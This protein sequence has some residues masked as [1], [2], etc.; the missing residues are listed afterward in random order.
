MRLI[1]YTVVV[2]V[3]W[4]CNRNVVFKQFDASFEDNRWQRSD[5]RSYSFSLDTADHYDLFVDFSYVAEVQF[6]EIPI[7]ITLT[8]P[9]GV[10]TPQPF[11]IRTKDANGKESGDCAGD[12]CD[13]R[14]VVFQNQSLSAGSYTVNLSNRFNHDYLPNVIGIGIRVTKSGD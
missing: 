9:D 14:Q 4:S 11:V 2:F 12:Y 6:A 1:F 5:T 8:S 13:L 7:Q 10:S 3:L